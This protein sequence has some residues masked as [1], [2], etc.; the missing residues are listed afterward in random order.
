M[1]PTLPLFLNEVPLARSR[2]RPFTYRVTAAFVLLCHDGGV[3]WLGRRPAGL[4]VLK[5]LPSDGLP[6]SAGPPL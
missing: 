5:G 6:G 2:S 3:E 4:G 1:Q